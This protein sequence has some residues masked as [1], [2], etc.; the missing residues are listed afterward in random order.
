[1]DNRPANPIRFIFSLLAFVAL[2]FMISFGVGYFLGPI[3][4][5]W[6]GL[7]LGLISAIGILIWISLSSSFHRKPK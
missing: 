5:N 1:M 6:G 7:A 4:G 2:F 3:L